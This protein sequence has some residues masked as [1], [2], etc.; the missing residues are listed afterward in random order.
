MQSKQ[1]RSTL[2]GTGL[3]IT[4]LETKKYK[5]V[6]DGKSSTRRWAN[7]ANKRVTL[8]RLQGVDTCID[9]FEQKL[10]RMNE[11]LKVM[12]IMRE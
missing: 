12:K 6:D 10:L 5:D 2:P 1:L 11:E 4:K 3:N 9:H 7:S 8:Q